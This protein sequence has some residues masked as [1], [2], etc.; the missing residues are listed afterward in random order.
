MMS[1][2]VAI[3]VDGLSKYYH[4]Y[5]PDTLPPLRDLRW[6]DGKPALYRLI[7]Q[8]RELGQQDESDLPGVPDRAKQYGAELARL[9]DCR[10]EL[11]HE[12]LVA[13]Q[14]GEGQGTVGS[15]RSSGRL[16]CSLRL[17]DQGFR[18][19]QLTT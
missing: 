3:R 17:G 4:M 6:L 8:Y 19:R 16:R 5:D 13:L 2:D 11:V 15:E 1:P 9:V 10:T 12:G 14:C 18:G 7:R